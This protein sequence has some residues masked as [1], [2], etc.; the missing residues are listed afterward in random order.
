[1]RHGM[2]YVVV[3]GVGFYERKE[4]KDILA[5]LRLVRNPARPDGAAPRASTC[6]PAASAKTHLD[7]VDAPGRGRAASRCGTRWARWSDEALLP[8]R[9]TLPLRRFRELIV[10]LRADAARTGR[11][12]PPRRA[13][14]SCRATRRPWP[15]RTPRRA[16]TGSRTSPSSCPPRPSTRRAT[17]SPTL[18]GFLDQVSLLSDTDRAKGEAPVVLMTLA[19]GQGPGVRRGVPGRASRRGWCPTRAAWRA[20]T[21]LEEERRPGLRGHDPGPGAAASLLGA[22]PPGLRP[23]APGEPSRFLAEIPAD[24]LV[25]RRAARRGL[26]GARAIRRARGRRLVGPRPRGDA[27]AAATLR[28]R[29]R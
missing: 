24:R 21:A 3:G 19:L 11:Q 1:M 13:P 6:P 16:R 2:P 15:R 29:P 14:G 23:A 17:K 7:E 10:G 26:R 27:A 25:R 5:Y 18:A 12:G 20:R 28:R 22:E 8:A 9:A 4:V